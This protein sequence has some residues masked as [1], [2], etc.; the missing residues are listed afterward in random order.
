MITRLLKNTPIRRK[1]TLLILSAVVVALT[2]SSAAFMVNHLS[3][4]K[5]AM[6]QELH[7]LA[8]VLGANTTAAL[9]FDDAEAAEQ[10][11]ASLRLQPNIESAYL[12]DAE[13]QRFAAYDTSDDDVEPVVAPKDAGV[14]FSNGFVTLSERVVND[15]ET[16]GTLSLHAS[17]KSV[18]RSLVDYLGIVAAVMTL[19]IAAAHQLAI[20]L[21]RTISEPIL[22]L[23]KTAE[24]V[25][26][27]EDYSIR[28]DSPG[29]DE[30][31]SL[32]DQFNRMLDQVQT[33]KYELQ[34]AHDRLEERV[35]ERT[36]Q[37]SETN[38]KLA[39]AHHD[40]V[41][42]ARHAGMAEIASG[43]LHNVGNVLN[44]VNVSATTIS[45]RLRSPSRRQMER[46][47]GMIQAHSDTIGDYLTNDE[48]G[49]H[50]PAFLAKLAEAISKE[51]AQLTDEAASL[52]KN[53][54]HIKAIIA[55]QQSYATTGGVVEPIDLHELFEDA[56]KLQSMSFAKHKVRVERD[57]AELPPVLADKQ[58]VLQIIINLIKNAKE[59]MLDDAVNERVLTLRT[60]G[61]GDRV[62]IDIADTGVGIEAE[63]LTRV[64]SHGYTTKSDGHGFGLHS[65]ANAA[66]EMSGE[67]KAHSDGPYCGARFT[68]TLPM[69]T[70]VAAV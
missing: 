44:S 54:D 66:A 42:A 38:D 60:C 39:R 14:Q 23:A 45:E 63:S 50:I 47:A 21:Q 12:Y 52:S 33:G 40:L 55:T 35:V 10:V 1:L 57:F 2:L 4:A 24:R 65:C 28:V 62:M 56:L 48:K 58:K 19:T 49:K 22:E 41:Q 3:F 25:S 7:A 68:L 67:L 31:G 70:A 26:V 6:V 46:I 29:N 13:G 17:L 69:Q 16:I 36:R 30:V 18:R 8:D 53:I 43:V 37:L 11:L 27:E 64:F 34:Q 61:V 51:D 20:R 9:V 59:A 5:N 32:Y 15:D